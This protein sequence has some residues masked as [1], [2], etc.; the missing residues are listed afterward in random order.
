M[1]AALGAV[2]APVP[3]ARWA[4]PR[5]G[6]AR[7]RCTEAAAGQAAQRGASP[8]Q[9]VGL[10]VVP[11]ARAGLLQGLLQGRWR[12]AMAAV[13]E[14]VRQGPALAHSRSLP[15]PALRGGERAGR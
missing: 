15:T 14:Q 6:G 7:R 3:L 11:F 5:G 9:P 1:L 13:P 10:C 4:A 2:P 8:F 12:Q